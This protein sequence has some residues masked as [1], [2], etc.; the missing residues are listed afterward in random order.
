MRI[1]IE[2]HVWDSN[3]RKKRFEG[4]AFRNLLIKNAI[5]KDIVFEDCTFNNSNIG[6][7]VKYINCQFEKCKFSGKSTYLG[8]SSIFD[9]C[10]FYNCVFLGRNTFHGATFQGCTISGLLKNVYLYGGKKPERR[11]GTSFK[12]C[13]LSGAVFKNVDIVGA[14]VF[15]ESSLPSTGIRIFSNSYDSLVR[16]ANNPAIASDSESLEIVRTLFQINIKSNQDPIIFDT[17]YLKSILDTVA[18]RIMFEA[19]V[20]GFERR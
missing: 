12:N 17:E 4:I 19:I 20:D 7:N 2:N 14:G 18:K 15:T 1:V 11:S 3:I 9:N 10:R 8:E 5:L 13:D 16:K 6:V